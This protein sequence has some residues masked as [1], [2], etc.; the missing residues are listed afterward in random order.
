MGWFFKKKAAPPAVPSRRPGFRPALETLEDRT[1]LSTVAT[2]TDGSVY[3]IFGA[4]HELWRH[5]D[6]YLLGN[7]VAGWQKIGTGISQVSVGANGDVDVLKTDTSLWK[8]HNALWWEPAS[9][10]PANYGYKTV[11]AG[12]NGEIYGITDGSLGSANLLFK[13]QNHVGTHIFVGYTD[14]AVAGSGDVYAVSTAGA[15]V[16]FDAAYNQSTVYGSGVHKVAVGA[17]GAVY[18]T[19][20]SDNQLW[21]MP[22]YNIFDP[23]GFKWTYIQN[24]VAQIGANSH[25]AGVNVVTTNG[26]LSHGGDYFQYIYSGAWT[27]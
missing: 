21:K 1:A 6:Y 5:Y 25:V 2:G 11:A 9:Y 17:Y 15:L 12:P 16:R 7:E 18:F 24:N 10:G 4:D 3:A 22:D 27:Y 8:I 14:V 26:A 23:T 13:W 19:W 20:G